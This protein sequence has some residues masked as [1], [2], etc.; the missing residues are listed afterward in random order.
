MIYPYVLHALES[1]FGLGETLDTARLNFV[2]QSVSKEFWGKMN[3]SSSR[4]AFFLFYLL[5]AQKSSVLQVLVDVLRVAGG[6]V[7]HSGQLLD[8][9]HHLAGVFFVIFAHDL[10]D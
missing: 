2:G 10:R 1:H 4:L 8:P 9:L 6:V 5:L 7:R 3:I